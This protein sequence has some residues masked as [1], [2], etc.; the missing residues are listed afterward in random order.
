MEKKLFFVNIV[1]NKFCFAKIGELFIAPGR[2]NHIGRYKD[3]RKTVINL[4]LHFR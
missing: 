3:G 2:T 4:S 1:Q